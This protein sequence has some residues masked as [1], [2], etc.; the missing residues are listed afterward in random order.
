[1]ATYFAKGS[2]TVSPVLISQVRRLYDTATEDIVA[3]CRSL[4][5]VPGVVTAIERSTELALSAYI[6]AHA[7]VEAFINE[8]F[9]S[10]FADMILG[11]WPGGG[12]D[13]RTDISA[14]LERLDLLTKL[15]LVPH[16]RIG[17]SL[18]RGEQ[19]YQDMALLT[20]LRNELIHYKMGYRPPRA[21]RILSQRGVA[22][23][24]PP[25]QEEGGPFAWTDRVSTIEGLR[26]AN[27]TACAT[28]RAL[29][30]LIPE[31]KRPRVE[32]LGGNFRA[33]A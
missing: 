18:N 13:D 5:R 21:V 4:K 15:I 31:E 28:V 27:N 23:S 12:G 25:E 33:I 11:P 1:M 20:Q 2:S 22:L 14:N 7:A 29:L 24:V 30:D 10:G 8:V 32:P 9:L 3:R 19:P 6:L 16:L 17:R 26:W